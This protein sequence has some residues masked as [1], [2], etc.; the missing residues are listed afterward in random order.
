MNCSH[1]IVSSVNFLV[2][3]LNLG[4]LENMLDSHIISRVKT[5]LGPINYIFIVASLPPFLPK[6]LQR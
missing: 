2:N 6:M 4:F 5:E 3:I 1:T